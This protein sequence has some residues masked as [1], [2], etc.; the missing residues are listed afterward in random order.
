MADIVFQ[1]GGPISSTQL[2]NLVTLIHQVDAKTTQFPD[3]FGALV[4]KS[5][6]QK[7]V[8]GVFNAGSPNLATSYKEIAVTFE[9]PL[10]SDPA[11]IQITLE[12]GSSDYDIVSFIKAGTAK[13]GGVTVVLDRVKSATGKDITTPIPVKI[14]YFA[15]AKTS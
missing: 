7:M 14:H 9:P 1:D 13:A 12:A 2:Q 11:T 8:A 4:N 5:I 10:T 15:V 6:A 3:Q